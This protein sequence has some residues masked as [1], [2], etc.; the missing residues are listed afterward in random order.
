[1]SIS[2]ECQEFMREGHSQ[3]CACGCQEMSPEERK[4]FW[5]ENNK[6]EEEELCR[7]CEEGSSV[8]D[9]CENCCIIM[10]DTLHICPACYSYID[11]D[12]GFDD[13]SLHSNGEKMTEDMIRAQIRC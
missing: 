12:D 3:Y 9:V 4:D 10:S 7:F 1:M 2:A 8:G 5:V 11:E 6:E 13:C